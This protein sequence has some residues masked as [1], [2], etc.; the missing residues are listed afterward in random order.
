[1]SKFQLYIDNKEVELFQDEKVTLTETIQDV[2]D[3][4]KVFTDFSKPFSLPASPTNNKIFKHYYRFNLVSGYSFDARKMVNAK[5]ELNTIPYKDGKLRLE[6]VDLENG[7]PK[8][9]RVTFFGNT[10]N[11]KN[12]LGD[13]EI[14]SL[15]WL[16]NF[17]TTYSAATI[18]QTL[19]VEATG[20]TQVGSE[21]FDN[22]IICPLISNKMRLYYDS[23]ST[24]PYTNT[25]GTDN[26]ALGGNLYPTNHTNLGADDVHGVLFEDLTYAIKVHLIV[27]A[28]QEKYEDITFSDDFFN[29]TNG[30]DAYKKLYMLCQKK[31]GRIF[32]DL[33]VAVKQITGF[34]VITSN[35]IVA[36][37]LDSVIVFGLKQNEVIVGT[38]SF[39]FPSGHPD[40]T[41]IIKEGQEP[42]ISKKF[43]ASASTTQQVSQIMTNSSQGYTLTIETAT[44]FT[45][46][47][48]TFTANAPSGN[49]YTSQINT[50]TLIPLEKEF[51]IVD[52]LP[53]MKVIDFLTGL[54]KM[55]NLTAF[56]KDGIM[57]VKTLE[58]FYNAGVNR[59]IT[60]YVD[61]QS[62]QVDKALPYKEIEFK[63]EDT[64]A[65][66]AKQHNES[67]GVEW[68][69]AK[70]VETGNLN[71]NDETFEVIAPFA[72]L[73]YERINGENSD[74]QW[75]FMA[76]EKNEPYFDKPVLFIGEFVNLNFNIRY[77]QGRTG[78]T[79]ISDIG[80]YWMPSNYV[81]RDATVSKEGIHFDVELSEW[82]TTSDFTETLFDK[83]YRFYIAGIFNLNKRLSKIKARLPKKFVL[84][85]TLADTVRIG[86]NN[87]KINS[88]TTDLLSGAS[89]LELLN[90]TVIDSSSTQPESGGAGG[91]INAPL[92][93]VLQ[94]EDCAN[95]GTYYEASVTLANLN[96]ANN[97]RVEDASNNAYK[98]VG[99]VPP[100]TYTSK[101]VTATGL[102][103]CPNTP[104]P[105]P[106]QYYG[107]KKCSNN[108]TSF[109]TSTAVGSPTYSINQRLLDGNSAKY[110]VTDSTTTDADNKTSVTIAS[111][112]ANTFNCTD[113]VTTYY[114]T[115]SPCCSGTSYVGYSTASN[116]AGN[117]VVYNNQ[118]FT[119]SSTSNTGTIDISS[120][121]SGTC[122]TYYYTL[123]SC[124]DGSIQHYGQSTCGNL[125]GS[126]LTYNS[127]CYDIQNTTNT[128]GTVNLNGLSSCSCT[129]LP[130]YYVLRDCQTASLVRTTTTTT[131]LSLTV[132]S[133]PSNASR[134]QDASTGKCYT[135]SGTT[136]DTN[137]YATT[138]GQVSDLNVLGCPG[139]PCTSVL[140]YHLQQCST[141]NTGFISSQTTD[142]I[143][144]NVNDF[145]HSGS[146]SGPLYKVLG[147]TGSGSIVGTVFVSSE[148][149]CPVYYEL[150]QCY[151]LQGSY[152][153]NQDT[154]AISLN[155]G[156]RVAT[157]NGMP[158]TV[159][160]I[161]V[162][163]GG[164]ANVGD[165]IDLGASGCPSIGVNT[166]YYSLQRCLDGT[167]GFLSTQ[168]V[169][170]I[171]LNTNDVVSVN[172]GATYQV[173]GTAT[174][175]SGTFVG[176]VTDT[177]ST[178]CINIPTPP[179]SPPGTTYYARFISCDDPT[180]IIIAV[181]STQQISTW[182]VIQEVGAFE[183]YRWLDNGQGVNPLELNSQNFT[184]FSSEN[185]AGANCLDCQSTVPPPPPPP[186]PP[187]AQ[188]CFTV[189]L[190]K[191]TVAFDLCSETNT[192]NVYLNASTLPA[193][194][195][196]YTDDSCST[197]LGTD[198]YFSET[199]GGNYYFW[200]S[201]AQT[202][203]GPFTQNC[204]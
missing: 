191:S 15:T 106:T 105:P 144:L 183:C 84:N 173:V 166:Q 122:T 57:H 201:S 102:T 165:V 94:L 41:A 24:I 44:S 65:T 98:V 71:S 172:G 12:V 31:E 2:R 109:R 81:S 40:F 129:V 69:A 9:Y 132:D 25:D 79:S 158:Y 116:L 67:Q 203:T 127:V 160:S 110:I 60:K 136:T 23:S 14:N 186:P 46:D 27:R 91:Q 128:T 126:Q 199:P 143:T 85:Y 202:L 6:G 167:T 61:P 11:L 151:T 101:V 115:L 32:D 75:G 4:S 22:A 19:S 78:T 26:T 48:I 112:P 148:T 88:I 134:V 72:H 77:L 179:V 162:S 125:N 108:S 8:A 169:N 184:I 154:N 54:F 176:V 86:D 159:V 121:S 103:G 139:T 189:A 56:V 5:I 42:I 59:D 30:P 170:D 35:P 99:N 163:G 204:P 93:N 124:T 187:P 80:N 149:A 188:Q 13:D 107:L 196:V 45:I 200:N 36:M 119:L 92:T 21:T 63:Y 3:V 29:L 87:Y 197:L 20:T 74:I 177:G 49:N 1:M 190:Y 138:I 137:L 141:G 33:S 131:D 133:N 90:E 175:T 34:P 185:T 28:I 192:R 37:N 64:G 10:V 52:N 51:V 135:A 70:Y 123:N 130:V 140:Y 194:S 193:A 198:T 39:N 157:A 97:Q 156:D 155:V 142:Q 58:S 118:T 147:T 114:Y 153:T 38:Y 73:K 47:S 117:T 150:Q 161:G 50:P 62:I 82:T 181:Y 16:N 7:K 55:F 53:S 89:D 43:N 178:N 113:G 83:Y 68:G 164:Y 18:E 168:T 111:A 17:N 182:W 96:L 76:D 66:L 195:Q 152:R 146:S 95:L 171:S 120:L 100:N 180:G 104:P 174:S 145:V